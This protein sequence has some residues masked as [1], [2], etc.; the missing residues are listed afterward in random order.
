MR[1]HHRRHNQFYHVCFLLFFRLIVFL[2]SMV[3]VAGYFSLF[4]SLAVAGRLFF[5]LSQNVNGE[6]MC[7]CCAVC[8][9]ARL[10]PMWTW[11]FACVSASSMILVSVFFF[12]LSFVMFADSLGN[13]FHFMLYL[14]DINAKIRIKFMSLGYIFIFIFKRKKHKLCNH[15]LA[16]SQHSH[17]GNGWRGG[18]LSLSLS[19]YLFLSHTHTLL[20]VLSWM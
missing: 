18:A 3:V 20:A 8:R 5:L 13:G 17:T 11:D 10:L 4:S 19:F 2:F 6:W 14:N 7:G 15:I 9:R 1:C 12:L 16:C